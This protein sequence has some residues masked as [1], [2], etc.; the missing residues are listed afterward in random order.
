[1]TPTGMG[2]SKVDSAAG[3]ALVSF[4]VHREDPNSFLLLWETPQEKWVSFTYILDVFPASV[5]AQS[6]R[7]GEAMH[8][9]FKSGSSFP[10]SS[11]VFLLVFKA[12][13]F[14]GSSLL[15]SKGWSAYCSKPTPCSSGRSSMF[16]KS[17]HNCGL[18]YL[19][20]LLSARPCFYHFYPSQCWFFFF[21]CGG[22]VHSVFGTFSEKITPFAVVYLLCL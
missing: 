1:M 18:L 10:Y 11:M 2:T 17:L 12:Q 6:L 8:E 14:V 16:L 19:I 4:S 21:H 15:W 9:P 7:A 20:F 5:L 22:S 13:T 3:M